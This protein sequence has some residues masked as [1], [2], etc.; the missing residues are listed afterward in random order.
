MRDGCRTIMVRTGI[1]PRMVLD[2]TSQVSNVV[3]TDGWE[4]VIA[5]FVLGTLAD[6]D[7][8]FTVLVEEANNVGMAGATPVADVNMVSQT[9]GIAP[10]IAASWN[11]GDDNEVR[12][13]EI[14]PTLQYLRIT[15]TIANNTGN[16]FISQAWRLGSPHQ[17]QVVQLAA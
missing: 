6:V 14:L 1:S 5:D 11:F 12:K 13:I 4:Y 10:E 16:A 8:T 2:N 17:A 9:D 15:V 7:A 3:D